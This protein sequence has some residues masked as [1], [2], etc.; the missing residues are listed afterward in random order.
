MSTT[1]VRL[2]M[3]PRGVRELTR[4]PEMSA[5]TAKWARIIVSRIR[6]QRA[7]TTNL[8]AK[9]GAG[10]RFVASSVQPGES[11]VDGESAFTKITTSD[12]GWHFVEYGT[13]L[14]APQAPFRGGVIDAGARFEDTGP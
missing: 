8:T 9:R 11:G 6:A 14:L 2:V 5:A 10:G 1:T 3:R 4:S 12:P 13:A 7:D